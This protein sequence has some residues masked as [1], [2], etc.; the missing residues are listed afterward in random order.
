MNEGIIENSI[1]PVERK[2]IGDKKYK[3]Y[4]MRRSEKILVEKL[5]EKQERA[6]YEIMGA[7]SLYDHQGYTKTTR[8]GFDTFIPSGYTPEEIEHMKA[9]VKKRYDDWSR[10]LVNNGKDME[11]S[12][13][14]Y[15]SQQGQTITEIKN[16]VRKRYAWVEDKFHDGLNQYVL[17]SKW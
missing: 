4:I 3:P 13:T 6:Y 1:E 16:R 11:Y 8:Y 15:I 5:D 2:L 10:Y 7:P 9:S 17:I 14:C 12:I